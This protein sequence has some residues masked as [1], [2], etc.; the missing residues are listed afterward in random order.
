VLPPVSKLTMEQAMYHFI[1]GYTAKV[2]G[3]LQ[4]CA[5]P[6]GLK[7]VLLLPVEECCTPVSIVLEAMGA[8]NVP[9]HQ[10]LH[11]KKGRCV[12]FLLVL[13]SPLRLF[14]H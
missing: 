1:S 5:I 6:C 3:A 2:A 12:A 10:S 9:L 8:G 4:C 14:R 11:S 13:L 7:G